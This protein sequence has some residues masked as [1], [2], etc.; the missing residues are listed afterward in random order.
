M[1]LIERG[2]LDFLALLQLVGG[3]LLHILHPIHQLVIDLLVSMVTFL[4]FLE[5]L[6]C[7]LQLL[8]QG[9][10]HLLLV[11]LFLPVPGH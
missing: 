4:K 7:L 3:L 2:V 6:P 11:Q 10:H 8:A 1:G 9:L 5:L